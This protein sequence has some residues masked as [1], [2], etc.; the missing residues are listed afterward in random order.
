MWS[1][2]KAGLYVQDA[3]ADFYPDVKALPSPI[4]QRK[5]YRNRLM[6][7]HLV[8]FG[9]G[10]AVVAAAPA[11]YDFDGTGDYLSIPDHADWPS[12]TNSFTMEAWIRF[13][14]VADSK[15]FFNHWSG[16]GEQRAF[17]FYW[18]HTTSEIIF[19]ASSD[20]G[21][22]ANVFAESWSPDVDIWY[23]VAVSRSGNSWYVFVDGTQLG[24]TTTDSVNILDSTANLD[25]GQGI[26]SSLMIG[27]MDEIRIS[28]TARYTT[29]FT[30]TSVEFT[31]DANTKFLM[32]CNETIVSG[33]T[34]SGATFVDSGST[35]HTVTEVGNAIRDTSIYKF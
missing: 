32:H 21:S 31:S 29:G 6:A 27:R 19:K 17:D 14:S 16:G 12:G 35:G 1:R 22:G 34:G 26:N 9:A 33:T 15:G 7:T 11:S 24:S 2:R 20:G 5:I 30:P 13:D 18:T 23:H 3:L 8:G 28:D 25:I 4:A 10:A